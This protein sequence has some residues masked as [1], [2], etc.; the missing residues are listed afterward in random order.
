MAEVSRDITSVELA[1]K[2]DRTETQREM[3]KE[4]TRQRNEQ[5]QQ[6]TQEAHGHKPVQ[7]GGDP[8]VETPAAR[9]ASAPAQPAPTQERDQAQP[10]DPGSVVRS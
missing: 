7:P 1:Y 5:R 8:A 3:R 6:E 4:R 2:S 10:V 9:P